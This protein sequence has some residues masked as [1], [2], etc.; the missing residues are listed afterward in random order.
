V[1][2]NDKVFTLLYKIVM[3]K[4]MAHPYDLLIS[5]VLSHKASYFVIISVKLLFPSKRRY[6]GT[7]V[8]RYYLIIYLA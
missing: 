2:R 8:R 3:H 4:K 5:F 7:K 1:D 6:E